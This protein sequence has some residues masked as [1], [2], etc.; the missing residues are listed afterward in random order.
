[1][2][3]VLLIANTD[4]YLFNFRSSL[5]KFL[6]EKG[7]QVV[8]VSPRGPYVAE[9]A[10]WG[11]RWIEWELDRRISWPWKEWAALRSLARIFQSEQPD[12]IHLHTMK[13]LIY[14]GLAARASNQPHL[15]ISVAGRG[16]VYTSNNLIFRIL[17]RVLS[18]LIGFIDRTRDPLWLFE[19]GGDLEYFRDRNLISNERMYLIEGVGLPLEKFPYVPEPAG[20]PVVLFAGRML[21]SKGVGLL[22]EAIRQLKERGIELN[23]I[24]VGRPDAGSFDSID[25]KTLE[26]WRKEGL[27]DWVGWEHEIASWYQRANLVVAPTTYGEGVPTVLLEAAASGRAIIATDHPGCAAVVKDGEN[28]LLIPKGDSQAL[29]DAIVRLLSNPALRSQMGKAGRELIKQ[30][31][32]VEAINQSTLSAYEKV[33]H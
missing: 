21:R 17:S 1:M 5:G 31:F 20:R 9:F 22:V 16:H 25:P 26:Q 8:F 18:R 33:S 12:I 3:I 29:A 32:S 23:C 4:W 11:I 24:L 15:V 28:G 13:A 27:V 30:K 14:G 10:S 2:K 7:Y 6:K 19:N